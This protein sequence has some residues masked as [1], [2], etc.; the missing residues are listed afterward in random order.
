MA[1][2]YRDVVGDG[3]SDVAGQLDAHKD[4]LHERMRGIRHK[5]A[6]MSGKGG[7]GKSTVTVNLAA[8]LAAMGFRIGVLDADI[9]GPSLAK[10]FGL[11]DSDLNWS[12]DGVAPPISSDGVKVMSMDFLLDGERDPVEWDGPVEDAFAWRGS[13]EMHAL[14]EFL[15]DTVWGELDFLII[16]LPPGTGQFATLKDLVPELDGTLVVS[17]PT[18]VSQMVVNR[19]ISMLNDSLKVRVL[20]VVENMSAYYHVDNELEQP[21]FTTRR[22]SNYDPVPVLA[23]IPFD[24]RMAACCDS[25]EPYVTRHKT[26]PPAQ[27]ILELSKNVCRLLQTAQV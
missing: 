21:L 14:R 23:R 19:S 13:L 8:G 6:V 16:D 18:E 11:D 20:G 25:G 22:P 9:Y 17:I 1:K 24:Y 15:T 5:L 27:A 26:A 3:G 12:E 4:R 10:M 7:V 2:R